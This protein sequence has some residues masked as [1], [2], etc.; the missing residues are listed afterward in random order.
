MGGTDMNR[1]AK[2]KY[3]ICGFLVGAVMFGSVAYAAT[4]TIEV[5][6]DPV[7]FI[8]DKVDKTPVNNEFNN[9]DR[10]VPASLIY[11]GTTYVPLRLV[12]NM[13]GKPVDWDGPT[14]SVL[15][16]DSVAGGDYLTHKA[17]S[18]VSTRMYSNQ[19]MNLDGQTYHIGLQAYLSDKKTFSQSYNLNGQYQ[20]LSFMFGIDDKSQYADS[21][22]KITIIGDG[23]E[24]WTGNAVYGVPAQS[25][26]VNVS[27]VLE[28]TITVQGNISTWN[29][30][31]TDIVNPI[32][33][34]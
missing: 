12:S 32:L 5:S 34:K 11:N 25:A 10:M 7:K 24:L 3:A 28:L 31:Y 19:T 17:P 13:L 8:V 27:G 9:N 14:R 30:Y 33:T 20:Y 4:T 18:V 26:T 22:S 1:F 21:S 23:K 16:G 15:I 29:Y 2:F 6:F